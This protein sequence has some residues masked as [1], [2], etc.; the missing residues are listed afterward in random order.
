MKKRLLI[1]TAYVL[2]ICMITASMVFSSSSITVNEDYYDGLYQFINMMYS[3]D[4][5]IDSIMGS[6]L[7]GVLEGMSPYSCFELA[8]DGV[9][10]SKWGIGAN[11]EK[12]R[13]G[14]VIVSV[15]PSSPAYK[16]GLE[17]G[18]VIFRVD[19]QTASAMGISIFK[20]YMADKSSVLLEVKDGKTGYLSA[21][22]IEPEPDYMNDVDY[23]ILDEAGY[24][25]INGLSSKTADIVEGILGSLESLGT[26]EIILDLRSLVS[27]EIESAA[28]VA[29]L[30]SSGGTMARTKAGTYNIR[31]HDVKFNV[32]ILVNGLTAG[33]GEVIASAV[34]GVV[35]G[36]PT[37]GEAYYVKTYPVLTEKAYLDYSAETGREDIIPLL[38]NLKFRGIELTDEEISGYL[39]I[40][41]SGVFN[42]KGT[43]ISKNSRIIPDVAVE[44][45]E[46]GY[47]DYI[48]GEGMIDIR[49]NYS[50]GSVN[51]DVY[52]AKLV[53][54]AL[55][56]FNGNM[57]V[58]FGK[59]MTRAVNEYKLGIGYPADGI[60]DMSTQAMLN[61]YAM[62]TAVLNDQ[63]VQA[64][65]LGIR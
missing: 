43:L 13:D 50:E 38:N 35:Y 31:K 36:Q 53:L 21:V 63:C 57:T 64:A 22:K 14:F 2:C 42:S 52:Q 34:G 4:M 58:V 20:K 54:N 61:T 46:I 59:D 55:G 40:V 6:S 28:Q 1:K 39:N 24:I 44:N 10:S 45:T 18:D 32:S 17:A 30:L 51:Y 47:M 26:E 29:G 41:E 3:R 5:G 23:V 56:I 15:N 9:D 19:K 8:D 25:R 49:R 16:A 27:M 12:V 33:A 65:I 60:L 37:A 62:K 7:N 11:L 48:P